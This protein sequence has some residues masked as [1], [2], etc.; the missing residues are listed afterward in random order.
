MYW[1]SCVGIGTA[2]PSA[3]HLVPRE[4]PAFQVTNY[5]ARDLCVVVL[6]CKRYGCLS[7]KFAVSKQLLAVINLLF[8]ALTTNAFKTFFAVPV[9]SEGQMFVCE[10]V[11]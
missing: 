11:V 10:A 1:I 8:T 9:D 5:R 2:L 6:K 7:G 3:L 4:H